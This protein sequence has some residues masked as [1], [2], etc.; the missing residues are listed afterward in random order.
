MLN[1]NKSYA[2]VYGHPWAKFEQGGTLYDGAGR[3]YDE[4]SDR[5][6]IQKE[7]GYVDPKQNTEN[8]REWL[9]RQLEGGPVQREDLFKKAEE[10]GMKWENVKNAAA[11]IKVVANKVRDR[12]VWRLRLE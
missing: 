9:Q 12:I 11:E 8:A 7:D 5:E 6:E 1:R 4:Q 10:E 3:S 2:E